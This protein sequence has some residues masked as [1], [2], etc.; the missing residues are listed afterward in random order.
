MTKEELEKMMTGLVVLEKQ[1]EEH[2]EEYKSDGKITKE[3][4]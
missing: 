3:E 4:R 2:L 1:L